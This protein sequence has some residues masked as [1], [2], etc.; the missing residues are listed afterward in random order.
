M[1]RGES[2]S[3]DCSRAHLDLSR[4]TGDTAQVALPEQGLGQGHP[5]GPRQPQPFCDSV[6]SQL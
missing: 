4:G 3:L 2:S 1:V 6:L 5:R